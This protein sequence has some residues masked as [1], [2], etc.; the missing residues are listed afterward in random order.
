M[1]F[2]QD[3]TLS[4]ADFG[5]IYLDDDAIPLASFDDLRV[6]QFT[7][8]M[9]FYDTENPQPEEVASNNILI[10]APGARFLD[11]WFQHFAAT[12]QFRNRVG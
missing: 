10:A 4:S 6:N 8:G 3:I 5:G 2:T 11:V 1:H 12:F 9:S 7:I